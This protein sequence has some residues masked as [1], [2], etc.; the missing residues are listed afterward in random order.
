MRGYQEGRYKHNVLSVVQAEFRGFIWGPIS[1]A[2]FGSIG[3]VQQRYGDLFSDRPIFAGGA[4][5]RFL[6]NDEGLNF[7]FDFARGRTGNQLYFT[8][9]E[10]F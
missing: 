5:L 3:D 8:L 4:G 7:R 6:L 1:G 9:G 2:V 10:A